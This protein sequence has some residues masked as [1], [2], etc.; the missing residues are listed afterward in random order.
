MRPRDAGRIL[1][2]VGVLCGISYTIINLNGAATIATQVSNLL[3]YIGI[4]TIAVGLIIFSTS[5]VKG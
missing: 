3:M 2:V 1:M 5:R 4:V